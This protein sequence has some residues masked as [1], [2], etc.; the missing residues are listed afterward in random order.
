MVCYR[1][2]IQKL[3]IRFTDCGCRFFCMLGEFMSTN[4]RDLE[5]VPSQL[6]G[7]GFVSRLDLCL[8]LLY[9]NNTSSSLDARRHI[10]LTLFVIDVR[11]VKLK[12]KSC[13]RFENCC[14]ELAFQF[15]LQFS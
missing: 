3:Q 4:A 8:S 11:L 5:G 2:S 7:Y 14:I 10:V 1:F 15:K 13:L 9:H 12:N 6:Y